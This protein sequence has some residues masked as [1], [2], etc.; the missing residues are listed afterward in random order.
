MVSGRFCMRK[1]YRVRQKAIKLPNGQ[2]SKRYTEEG[3]RYFT[4]EYSLWHNLY[5]RVNS[6]ARQQ[7][8]PKYIGCKL[9][10]ESYDNFAEWCQYQI[11][12]GEEGWV[13]DK[14]ILCDMEG[15][16]KTY[17]P[18]TCV[19]VP[20]V[21][22]SFLTMRN[23]KNTTG[24]SGVSKIGVDGYKAKFMACCT[25]LDGKNTTLGRTETVEEAYLL[26]RTH[27]IALANR[28]ATEYEDKID[29]RAV[30]YLRNFDKY[31]DNL[32]IIN[33]GE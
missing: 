31:I 18:S 17:S 33:K 1:D 6:R 32:A 13:L 26:Y 11:G 14:D 30:T 20:I 19:F 23:T 22:N 8:D 10:F 24:F 16:V 27:K 28:L 25:N 2:Y 15:S 21:I 4:K 5:N 9:D 3:K 7:A 12:F 29:L